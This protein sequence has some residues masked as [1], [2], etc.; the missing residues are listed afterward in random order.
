M[1]A[2]LFFLSYTKNIIVS[3]EINEKN[4]YENDCLIY[5]EMENSYRIFKI[6]F[7]KNKKL[8]F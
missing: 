1:R 5:L 6:F 4:L 3:I 2:R 7:L 8:L